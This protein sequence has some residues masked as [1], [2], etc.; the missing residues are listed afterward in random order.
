MELTLSIPEQ[1]E[2]EIKSVILIKEWEWFYK[3]PEERDDVMNRLLYSINDTI[4]TLIINK[5]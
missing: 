1:T 2:Y 5:I 4:M 3:T